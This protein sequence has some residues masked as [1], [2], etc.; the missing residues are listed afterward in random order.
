MPDD[1]LEDRPTPLAEAPLAEARLAEVPGAG[2]RPDLQQTLALRISQR[3]LQR[4]ERLARLRPAAPDALPVAIREAISA[5]ASAA[6]AGTA[7]PREPVR[8]G[9]GLV[10]TPTPASDAALEEFLRALT[11]GLALPGGAGPAPAETGTAEPAETER[12]TGILRFP[13]PQTGA[14][15]PTGTAEAQ[16]QAGIPADAPADAPIDPLACDLDR[17]PGAGPG[18]VWALRR[19]GI[20]RLA[21]LALLAPEALAARL[22][23]LGRLVPAARWI[24]TARAAL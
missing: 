22:G 18:L 24:E 7:V 11:G 23:P 13:A 16:D 5:A 20:A 15:E 8:S 6:P 4:T 17:L 14:P 10:G 12:R 21:D 1:R 9:F 19:A 3:N 2:G